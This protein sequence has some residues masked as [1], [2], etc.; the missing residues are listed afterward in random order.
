MSTQSNKRSSGK[1]SVRKKQAPSWVAYQSLLQHARDELEI[2]CQSDRYIGKTGFDPSLVEPYLTQ[3]IKLNNWIF[4]DASTNDPADEMFQ[5]MFV[6]G[7]IHQSL[8]KKLVAFLKKTNYSFVFYSCNNHQITLIDSQVCSDGVDRQIVHDM[9]SM[10]WFQRVSPPRRAYPELVEFQR[11]FTYLSNF[12]EQTRDR[13]KQSGFIDTYE[14][15]SKNEREILEKI[16]KMLRVYHT[17]DFIDH[18]IDSDQEVE[19]E[20]DYSEWVDNGYFCFFMIAN[21]YDP[22]DRNLY[23][24]LIT[25]LSKGDILSPSTP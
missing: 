17:Y 18:W 7:V 21:E 9:W 23:Q 11:N 16:K 19:S 22:T 8:V 20:I 2:F 15:L 5:A 10:W 4:T 3:I 25:A 14:N 6:S 1:S 12:P 24:N 13:I